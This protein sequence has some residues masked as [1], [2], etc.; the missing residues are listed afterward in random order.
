MNTM[1]D[2][3]FSKDKKP[4]TMVFEGTNAMTTDEQLAFMIHRFNLDW[5]TIET[6]PAFKKHCENLFPTTVKQ[7]LLQKE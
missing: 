3:I 1:G 4:T 5:D 7:S 2:E 6:M